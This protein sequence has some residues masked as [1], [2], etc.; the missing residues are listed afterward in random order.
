M[1]EPPVLLTLPVVPARIK[2]SV[3][4]GDIIDPYV[5]PLHIPQLVGIEEGLFHIIIAPIGTSPALAPV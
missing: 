3:K 2:L 5:L 4:F 1:G